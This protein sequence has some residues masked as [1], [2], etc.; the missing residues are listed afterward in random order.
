MNICLVSNT[1]VGGFKSFVVNIVSLLIRENCKVTILL[2]NRKSQIDIPGVEIITYDI[3]EHQRT[4]WKRY[5]FKIR[6]TCE[7]LL[8]RINSHRFER[9]NLLKHALFHAQLGAAHTVERC[10]ETINLSEFDCAG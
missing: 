8:Y 4:S 9:E 7:R 3:S 6:S 1:P 2:L 10:S 5:Y